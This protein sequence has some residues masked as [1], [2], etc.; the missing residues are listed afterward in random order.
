[1]TTTYIGTTFPLNQQYG[2]DEQAVVGSVRQQVDAKFTTG[3]NLV[4]NT[5]WFGPQFSNGSWKSLQE[6]IVSGQQYDRLF[7]IIVIDPIYV[8]DDEIVKI[9][10]SLGI[11]ETYIMGHRTNSPYYFNFESMVL[12][13]HCPRYTEEQ[14][15]MR[16][17]EYVFLCYQRKPRRHRVELMQ[18]LSNLQLTNQGI[19]TLGENNDQFN[20][21][22]DLSAPS[23]KLD[24]PVDTINPPTDNSSFGIVN[25]LCS[26][27]RLDIWQKHFLN[28]VSETEFNNWHDLF[29]S[30]KTFKPLLG[31]RPFVIHGQTA[32]YKFLSDNGFKTFN[33]YWEGIEPE[34]GMDQIG[35]I[36]KII[37]LLCKKSRQEL[38]SMYQ[39]MLPDL[40]YN[41]NRFFE[42]AKEQ[43]YKIENLF[44]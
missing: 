1:M 15:M 29:V 2:R 8:S 5:T 36:V 18:Q 34:S 44:K 12:A 4:I 13:Q 24:E 11:T 10:K 17:P 21:S 37:Q 32:V 28:V 3:K 23:V 43:Q 31:L 41:K 20:W 26:I 33:Q 40:E 19:I 6:L 30:E 7:L 39:D 35:D 42:F 14:L 25:D 38:F 16:L 9:T 22:E 27:G